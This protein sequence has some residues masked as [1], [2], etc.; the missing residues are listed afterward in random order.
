MLIE[1]DND[2]FKSTIYVYRQNN[3]YYAEETKNGIYEITEKTFNTIKNY[4]K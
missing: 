4:A 3:K 1:S 2:I